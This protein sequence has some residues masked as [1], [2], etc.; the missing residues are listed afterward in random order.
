MTGLGRRKKVP[1]LL[2]GAKI[3]HRHCGFREFINN[4]VKLSYITGSIAICVVELHF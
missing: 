1:K 2:M 4:R 3:A